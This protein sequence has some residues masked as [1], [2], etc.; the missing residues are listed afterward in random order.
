MTIRDPRVGARARTIHGRDGAVVDVQARNARAAVG[1]NLHEDVHG[2]VGQP[3]DDSILVL[4]E[5]V[6]Q[7]ALEQH[8]HLRAVRVRCDE[9]GGRSVLSCADRRQCAYA[10]QQPLVVGPVAPADVE[11]V[12]PT[13]EHDFHH[14]ALEVDDSSHG[15]SR[16]VTLNGRQLLAVGRQLNAPHDGRRAERLG[17]RCRLE[18]GGFFRAGEAACGEESRSQDDAAN[19]HD[20]NP[21]AP[22]PGQLSSDGPRLASRSCRLRVPTRQCG[23]R[24]ASACGRS[25]S[26]MAIAIAET[27]KA[28]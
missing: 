4:S 12:A 5:G 20:G 3:V 10:A 11:L 15:D 22:I 14:S 26:H 19:A 13:R 1:W 23:S 2:V 18:L 21:P 17:Q 16:G 25:R 8:A 6:S 7:P 27:R 24:A 28:R 9:P